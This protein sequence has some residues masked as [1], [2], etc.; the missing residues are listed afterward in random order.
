MVRESV[1][2]GG[3]SCVVGRGVYFQDLEDLGALEGLD[4]RGGLDGVEVVSLEFN[5]GSKGFVFDGE[6]MGL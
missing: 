3:R 1:G 5:G 2:R 6:S 4:W